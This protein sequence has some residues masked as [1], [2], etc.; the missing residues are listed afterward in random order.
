MTTKTEKKPV[1]LQKKTHPY[2][3][4]EH[5]RDV[6]A[7]LDKMR[8]SPLAPH[9]PEIR[10]LVTEIRAHLSVRIK[11]AD[12]TEL[13]RKRL[14]HPV[15]SF[16]GGLAPREAGALR[17]ILRYGEDVRVRF[18]R[19]HGGAAMKVWIAKQGFVPGNTLSNAAAM[20]LRKRGILVRD[21]TSEGGGDSGLFR[22][23]PRAA[24]AGM[25]WTQ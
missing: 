21:T 17:T 16:C 6:S 12:L 25:F 10:P 2:N 4:S 20:N 24:E 18:Y 23:A 15:P 9:W 5:E 19:G 8:E 13:L 7:L 1:K 11:R 22:L 14:A 3:A